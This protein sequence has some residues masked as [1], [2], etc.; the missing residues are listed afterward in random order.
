MRF[1]ITCRIPVEKGNELAKTVS[2]HSTIQSIMEELK[3]EAAYFSEIEG[4]RVGYIVV[5][6]DEASQIAAIVEPL[7]LR[8]GAAI[9]VHRVMT[10][11][12]LGQATPAI[13]Q[14]A[15]KYG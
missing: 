10:P 5:N 14:A 8:L 9:Q 1:M 2:L 15:Q 7:F 4:A 6:I 12:E 13:R 11:E 3:P